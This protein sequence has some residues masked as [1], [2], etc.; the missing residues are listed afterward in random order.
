M[1]KIIKENKKHIKS[2]IKKLTGTDNDDIEQEVYIR[3][4]QNLPK[5]EEMGKFKQW[6][7]TLTANV[8]RDYFRSKKFKT[9]SKEVTDNNFEEIYQDSSSP[10]DKLDSKQ[11][12]KIILKAVDDLPKIYREVIVLFE[13]EEYSLEKISKKLDIPE[14]TVKSRLSNARKI[15]SKNLSFLKGENNE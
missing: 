5:Y 4:W 8:C 7:C 12:Q 9:Q 14:G 1:Q 3:A 2:V 6:I 11:R 15:L 13:F 10:E